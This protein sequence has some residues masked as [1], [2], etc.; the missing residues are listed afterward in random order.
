MKPGKNST[1][2]KRDA[3]TKMA[4]KLS[5]MPASCFM[6]LWKENRRTSLMPTRDHLSSSGSSHDSM[7]S[8]RID[9]TSRK[10]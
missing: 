2:P 3:Q 8:H 9:C 7:M 5:R 6:T 10:T 4:Y 1:E